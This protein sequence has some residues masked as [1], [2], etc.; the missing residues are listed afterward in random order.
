MYMYMCVCVYVCIY[1]YIYIHTYAY[2]YTDHRCALKASSQTKQTEHLR[3]LASSSQ[4]L[5]STTVDW[6]FFR[7]DHLIGHPAV[8]R[9]C[10]H[11][12]VMQ[13]YCIYLN[14]YYLFIIN[15]LRNYWGIIVY[16]W[17]CSVLLLDGLG[18]IGG[19]RRPC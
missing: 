16:H 6:H 15:A 5:G 18:I 9:N 10:Q 14:T 12:C 1:I 2:T 17:C 4:V 7:R 13:Q 3:K 11:P 8:S 19:E